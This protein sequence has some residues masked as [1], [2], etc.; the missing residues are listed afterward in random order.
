MSQLLPLESYKWIDPT[1]IDI[2][3]VPNDSPIG[4]ILEVDLEYSKEL[5]NTHNDYPLAPEH[6]EVSAN[7]LSPFQKEHFPPIRGT[8]KK[9]V[10]NLMDKENYV[11]HYQNLQLY[12]SLGMRIKK[13]HRVIQFDQSCWMKPYIDL[14]IEKRKEATRNGDQV[15]KDL[16]KLMNNAVFGKT[17]ENLRKRITLFS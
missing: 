12:V 1:E 4:Y 6:L 2:L 10:P 9:L 3:S 16:F 7:M 13:I 5:H 8:V 14:N 17:M 11:I 15:G